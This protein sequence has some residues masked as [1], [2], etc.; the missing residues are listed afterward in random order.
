MAA[1]PLELAVRRR[2]EARREVVARP[3]GNRDWL[4][5]VDAEPRDAAAENIREQ[6]RELGCHA[7]AARVAGHEDACGVDVVERARELLRVERERGPVEAPPAVAGA[8]G[9][10]PQQAPLRQQLAHLRVAHTA[11]IARA[12]P[13]QDTPRIAGAVA[14][15]DV[16]VEALV[17]ELVGKRVRPAGRFGTQLLSR[18]AVAT[19]HLLDARERMAREGAHRGLAGAVC[20]GR[21]D[22][23]RRQRLGRGLRDRG[24]LHR[25]DGRESR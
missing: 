25:G 1:Q 12:H 22:F 15:R 16:E 21:R 23:E 7:P 5:G 2:R 24:L 11:A 19:R 13:D 3:V 8:V 10:D 20:N 9:A 14:L 4:V 6:E 18:D 17:L